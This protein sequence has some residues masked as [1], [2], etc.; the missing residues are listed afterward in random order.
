MEPILRKTM[1]LEAIHTDRFEE[2]KLSSLL[3]LVQEISGEHSSLLNYSWE[4]LQEKQLFWAIIRHRVQ[5]TR[6]PKKGETLTLETWPMPTTRTAYPRSVIAY[7]ES[8][9]ELFRTIALWVL[10]D[11]ST[12]AMILPGKSGIAVNGILRGTELSVPGSLVP[13]KLGAVRKRP[14]CFTDLDINGHMNNCRYLDWI[15][16]LLPSSFHGSHKPRELTLC[17]LSEA[18]EGELLDLSWEMSQDGQLRT[19]IT[20]DGHRTFAAN[21]VY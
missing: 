7:D 4:Q 8:G 16:D 2:L 6:L 21:I 12:R 9:R 15:G 18:R 1:K 10:M 17:Y 14:V 5:I 13:G 20:R 3:H 11:P 19:E